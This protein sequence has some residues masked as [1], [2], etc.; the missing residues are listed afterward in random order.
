M[1][2]LA[3]L[4]EALPHAQGT[5]K[6]LDLS[7][8]SVYTVSPPRI[9]GRSPRLASHLSIQQTAFLFEHKSGLGFMVSFMLS[10]AEAEGFQAESG[11]F[12]CRCI[13]W[14]LIAC[15]LLKDCNTCLEVPQP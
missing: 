12:I 14:D 8:S 9:W 3:S 15:T 1:T 5:L 6:E 10:G 7:D 11:N 2:T 13:P 4:K